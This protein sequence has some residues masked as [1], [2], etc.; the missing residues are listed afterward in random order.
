MCWEREADRPV[1]YIGKGLL[2]EGLRWVSGGNEFKVEMD[3]CIAKGDDM[4]RYVVH[5]KP[6]N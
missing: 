6:I 5:K 4:G 2:E 3:T 1:C